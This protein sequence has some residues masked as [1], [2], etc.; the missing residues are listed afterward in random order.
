MGGSDLT[1]PAI[2]AQYTSTWCL[3]FSAR[4]DLSLLIWSPRSS[5]QEFLRTIL[6]HWQFLEDLG[7][8]LMV[9]LIS[10]GST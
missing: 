2:N 1:K 7:F 5:S 3:L 10:S 6:D 9:A 8:W 4:L